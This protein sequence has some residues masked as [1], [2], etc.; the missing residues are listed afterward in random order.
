[1]WSGA[2][3][4]EKGIYKLLSWLGSVIDFLNSNNG[5]ITAVATVIL[6]GIT[7]WYVHL[8][9]RYVQLTQENVQ[10]TQE[11]VEGSYK[12][13]V[14][15][16]LLTIGT[17]PVEVASKHFMDKPAIILSVKNVG[18]GIAYKIKF[19]GDFSVNPYKI[20]NSLKKINFLVN[21]LDQLFPGEERKSNS[22]FTGG[23][24]DD[25]SQLRIKFTG[26]WEDFK[27]KEHRKDFYL[28]F[29]GTE[30]PPEVSND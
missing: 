13:E 27:G 7:G 12:P 26:T 20:G 29:A 24:S 3:E 9:R 16:R 6:A 15:L 17:R 28:N 2:G 14:V 10:L 21:G 18:P 25:P 8:M 19:E 5:I 30:L 1:M 23:L 11:M 4:N 22:N